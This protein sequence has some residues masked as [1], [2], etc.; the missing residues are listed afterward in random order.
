[1]LEL[2]RLLDTR[3]TILLFATALA[4]CGSARAPQTPTPEPAALVPARPVS[5]THATAHEPEP[6]SSSP[7]HLLAEST[8]P[9]SVLPLGERVFVSGAPLLATLDGVDLRIDEAASKG[10][11]DVL[12]PLSAVTAASGVFPDAAWLSLST[13]NG[14]T[15]FG[16]RY[17]WQGD[18][19][20][21]VGPISSQ[22]DLGVF[23]WTG[24]RLLSFKVAGAPFGPQGFEVVRGKAATLPRIK[25]MPAA[26]EPYCPNGFSASQ[27]RAF[28][29][30]EVFLLGASCADGERA[31]VQRWGA[32]SPVAIVE[33]LPDSPGAKERGA[34][35]VL[36][37]TSAS[38]VWLGM[39]SPHDGAYLAHFDGKHWAAERAPSKHELVA[40]SALPD[41]SLWAITSEKRRIPAGERVSEEKTVTELWSRA[42]GAQWKIVE[43]P[44]V[45]AQQGALT[46]SAIDVVARAPGDL[47]VEGRYCPGRSSFRSYDGETLVSEVDCRF[48]LFRTI[49]PTKPLTAFPAPEDVQADRFSIRRA[50]PL[51]GECLSNVF[52]VLYRLGRNAPANFD[53]PAT[54]AALKG[55]RELE[56]GAPTFVET[57][58]DGRRY[59]GALVRDQVTGRQLAAVIEKGVPGSHASVLCGSP[60][61]RRM[62]YIDLASGKITQI[63]GPDGTPLEQ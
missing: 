16:L 19:W 12:G 27:F 39:S 23:E 46:W 37:A 61:I 48:A 8:Y 57:E 34:P 22:I 59:F 41:G 26:V 10:L 25:R 33:T 14:R 11:T 53:Y 24:A 43:M 15:G 58:E 47:W 51:V 40:A 28:T 54:R 32:G 1:M 38:D 29:S 13:S 4:A 30:G 36:V 45:V 63:V 2:R 49:A 44:R 5:A 9:L 56:D 35:G 42:P 50:V 18:E 31:V 7:F 3:R 62:L 60:E 20:K 52:V 21:R 6:P 17:R 55:H